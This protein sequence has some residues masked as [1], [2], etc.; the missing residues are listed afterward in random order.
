[1]SQ[2]MTQYQGPLCGVSLW[3]QWDE[4]IRLLAS[5]SDG[6]WYVYYVGE[7][8]PAAPLASG[9]F[10]HFL[11]ELGEL[12]RRDHQEEYLGIVYADSLEEPSFIKVYD[13][14]NLGAYCGSSGRQILSGWIISRAQPVDLGAEFPNPGARRRWWQK[15]FNRGGGTATVHTVDGRE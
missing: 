2:F 11:S 7:S 10:L 1:M 12:L 5:R 14:N 15:L 13:P 4:L 8:V 6:N 9:H 3:P